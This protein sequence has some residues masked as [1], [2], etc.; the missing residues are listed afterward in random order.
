MCALLAGCSNEPIVIS[1]NE[2]TQTNISGETSSPVNVETAGTV[3]VPETTVTGEEVIGDAVITLNGTSVTVNGTG[4]TASDCIVTITEHGDYVISG[5]LDNG[6]IIVNAADADKVKLIF[7]GVNIHCETSAPIYVLRADKVII[8]LAEGSVNMVSDGVL[9]VLAEGSDEPDA[10]IFSKDDLKI[11]GTGTLYVT[12]NYMR[13][14]H[15][16]DTL[17]IEEATI[18][19]TAADDGLRGND[20]VE[21]YCGYIVVDAGADGIRTNNSEEEGRGYILIYTGHYIRDGIYF[22]H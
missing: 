1:G 5:T 14:I 11:K 8:E 3:E 2:N 17:Q 4:A 18:Y 10:A 16:K 7:N 19:V 12:G 21:I 20:A 22:L 6:Q 15:T 13:G 9:Y